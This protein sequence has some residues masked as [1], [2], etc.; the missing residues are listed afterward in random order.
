MN[1]LS[2][3][4]CGRPGDG[5]LTAGHGLVRA[6]AGLGVPAACDGDFPRV[7][8]RSGRVRVRVRIFPPGAAAGFPGRPDVLVSLHDPSA[9]GEMST[10]SDDGAVIFEGNPPGY[11]EEDVALAGHV[12][13]LM[14]GL[15]IPLRD[16]SRH[17]SGTRS[18]RNAV[19]LGALASCLGLP[20]EV[21]R[22]AL[23][24]GLSG[25]EDPV[26][27]A[28][29]DA[30][31]E[32]YRQGL[33]RGETRLPPR[34]RPGPFPAGPP[35]RALTGAEALVEG[36]RAG[37]QEV[38][39]PRFPLPAGGAP[40]PAPGPP[41]RAPLRIFGGRDVLVEPV[42][43]AFS[44]HGGSGVAVHALPG[45][46]AAA[47]RALGCAFAARIRDPGAAG[48]AGPLALAVVNGEELPALSAFLGAAL[49]QGCPLVVAAVSGPVSAG[50]PA[51]GPLFI[52]DPAACAPV[53][54]D[55]PGTEP[56]R[57]L[58]TTA[59]TPLDGREAAARLAARV[60]EGS[61]P[62]L[63]RL[64]SAFLPGMETEHP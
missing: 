40:L 39:V 4:F 53:D 63:L 48:I 33:G 42:L 25:K 12:G 55:E 18:H 54:A 38:S 29:R 45:P 8:D 49:R 3:L 34:F 19:A 64:S 26:R 58:T 51:G 36:F 9:I 7:G 52:P 10:L 2:I 57:L 16:I 15:G 17:V 14:H 5:A 11:L 13:P 21:V 43:K 20:R 27:G 62:G 46:T 60:A 50:Q 61:R 6:L 35:L 22:E 1:T 56:P 32:G 37:S 31:D 24:E 59:V 28:A 47:A 44:L 23:A 30:F 41:P